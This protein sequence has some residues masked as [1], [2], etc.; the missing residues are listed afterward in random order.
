VRLFQ[1]CSPVPNLDP[2]F[3][4]SQ[5]PAR[6]VEEWDWLFRLYI[7]RLYCYQNITINHKQQDGRWFIACMKVR[8]ARSCSCRLT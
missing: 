7:Q 8:D 2:A 4:Y 3:C 6:Y 5:T 1:Y